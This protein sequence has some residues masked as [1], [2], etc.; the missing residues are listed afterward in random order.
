M[1]DRLPYPSD[2]TDAEWDSI[3][4]ILPLVSKIGSPRIVDL[5]E[6]INAIFYLVDNGIKWRA[7][8]HDYPPWSTV[9]TYFRRWT[10]NGLWLKINAVLLA[11][12][13]LEAGR[14]AQPSLIIIDSQSVKMAQKG[15]LNR[16]LTA[17]SA[18]KAESGI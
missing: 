17:T 15:G 18:S 9:Y 7:M 13:R 4:E 1:M 14:H 12:V 8:P 11:R 16:V 5:R 10:R 6:V 3:K 2:L